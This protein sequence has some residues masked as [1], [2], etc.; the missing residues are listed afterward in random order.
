MFTARCGDDEFEHTEADYGEQGRGTAPIAVSETSRSTTTTDAPR[1][2][3]RPMGHSPRRGKRRGA[4]PTLSRQLSARSGWPFTA[5]YAPVQCASDRE[6]Q[7][8]VA[9]E[10]PR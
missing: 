3:P 5:S 1:S 8:G 6:N 4:E 2:A 9:R 7:S 10:S